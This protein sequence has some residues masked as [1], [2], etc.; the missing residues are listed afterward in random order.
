[1]RCRRDDILHPKASNHIAGAVELRVRCEL[2]RCPWVRIWKTCARQ[3][4]SC[5]PHI[6]RIGSQ[7]LELL[8]QAQRPRIERGLSLIHIFPFRPLE[9]QHLVSILEVLAPTNSLTKDMK[10]L[11]ESMKH[12]FINLNLKNRP[13][14]L[15]TGEWMVT[16]AWYKADIEEV[17]EILLRARDNRPS[18]EDTRKEQE[19]SGKELFEL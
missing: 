6:A 16:L 1:M 7:I 18:F 11:H 12:R 8:L 2:R 19:R 14:L 15:P 10:E 9:I 13:R 3:P 4:L 5:G 17:L